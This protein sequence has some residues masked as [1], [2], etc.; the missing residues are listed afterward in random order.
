LWRSG[1]LDA[2]MREEMR[3]HIEAEAERLQGRGLDS[4]EAR[5][6]AHV[7][8]GGLEKY[9]ESGRDARGLP[10]VDALALDARLGVRM[11]I[12]HRGLT[13][14]GGFAMAVA[15]AIGATFFEVLTEVLNPALPVQEGER[16]VALRY[17]TQIPGSAERR[18]LR[19]FVEWRQDVRTVEHLGAFRTAQHNLT[20]GAAPH[21]PIKVAEITAEGFTVAGTAPL[22][23][24]YLLATDEPEGAPPVVVIGYQA[25]QSRFSGDP[26]IAGR[27][28]NLGGT[29]HTVVGVMPDGF[30]FPLDHQYWMPLRI[31][32]LNYEPLQGPQLY[33]FG[34]LAP[35]VTMQEAQA[36]LTIIGQRAAA[37]DPQRYGRLR[38]VVLPYT[39]EHLGVTDPFRV[40]VLR[41]ALL[42]VGA[43]TFIV[44][45]NLAI[46]L[47][48]RTVT[49][50]GEIAV[51]TALGASRRRILAQLF[52]EALAL[53]SVGAGVGLVLAHLALREIQ[54]LIVTNGAVPFWIDVELSVGAVMYVLGLAVL[55]A[56]IMGVLPGLKATGRGVNA[57]LR[58]LDGRTGARLGPMWTALVVGQV[59]VAVA[60]LPLPLCMA[61]GVVR[62]GFAEPRFAADEFVVGVVALVDEASSVDA[63]RVAGRQ[64]ELTSRLKAEPGVSAVTF[65]SGVPGF[66]PGR[67]FRFEE[68]P[69]VKY[70]GATLGADT[71]DV[72]LDL[73]DAYG[74]E[75]L[76]G[77]VFTAADLGAANA[78]IVNRT[79]V[80]HFVT[81]SP[82]GVR[83]RYVSPYE[84]RG[85]RAETSYQIVGVIRDFP[86]FPPEPGSDGTAT[87]YHPASPGDVHPFVLSV[88]LAG[89]IPGG[90]ID[91]FR[92]IGVEVDPALQLRRLVPLS[93]FYVQLRAFWRYLA[94]GL[95]L[96]TTSVLLLSA[97]GIYAMMSFTVARRSREIAIRAALGAA[98]QRLLLNVFGRAIAQ[99]ALGLAV[100]LLLA[101]AIFQN[102]DP[103]RTLAAT[104][105]LVAS[106]IVVV[107][108][109]AALGP[110]R[111]SLRIN[112]M[113][114]LR[115]DG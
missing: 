40:W 26:Q 48:A 84:R 29:W 6:Q 61:W 77:R 11:L 85:T 14:V 59:A 70:A 37:A 32:P 115:T 75:L 94:V 20:S 35:G 17:A 76:A 99:L 16:V 7:L 58:E 8:F 65:S 55:A 18:V 34:R 88:R 68:G 71:L 79:F 107:G 102:F 63:A 33:M 97:A 100:G 49:R 80:Q 105:A 21:E 95:G 39:H 10:W 27:T 60:V 87:V 4:Q 54:S 64:L 5:R 90:F 96:V 104:I 81:G 25:W 56:L 91:R 50:L 111:R 2:E 101:V 30:K 9:K 36:E 19:D 24:R 93:D 13:L 42:F 57:N 1:R 62:M 23:G 44:S 47:Y 66:G 112:A 12:K 3:F 31:N 69:G 45:V 52:V 46:L 106:V 41:L 113:D 51:R 108:L 109:L 78:V 43:L 98:P 53:S 103:D 89:S 74:A 38:P 83:F 114:A 86:S 110:A 15:I 73:F 72:G 67:S 22:I 82:L 92:S 28:I